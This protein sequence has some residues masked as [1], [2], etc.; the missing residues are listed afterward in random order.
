[1]FRVEFFCDDKHI[2]RVHHMLMGVSIGAPTVQPVINAAKKNGK[3]HATSG[4]SQLEMFADWLRKKKPTEMN[5]KGM[6]QFLT[7]IGASGNSYS[8]LLRNAIDAGYLKKTGKG[9]LSRYSVHLSK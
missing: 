3:I 4:G 7:D 8:A 2:A 5:A 6:R 1:M 9:T